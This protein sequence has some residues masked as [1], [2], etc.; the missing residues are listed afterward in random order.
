MPT[1]NE[2]REEYAR[3]WA[4]MEIRPS[5][6][7][8]IEATASKIIGKKTRYKAVEDETGVPWFVVGVIH[9]ME[10]GCDFATH[11]HNGDSL[12]RRTVQVPAGRPKMGTP[13][14]SWKESA[15]D[16]LNMKSL[17]QIK[18][19]SAE[20]ICY[21]LERYNGWGYRTYHASV[22]SPY[23]WSGTNHYSRGKY[24]ADG[25][26]SSSAVSGQSGAVAILKRMAEMDATIEIGAVVHTE[27]AE[28]ADIEEKV[29]TPAEAF[30]RAEP[31]ATLASWFS[32]AAFVKVNGLADEG[33]RLAAHIKGFKTWFWR[34]VTTMLTGGTVVTVAADTSKGTAQVVASDPKLLWIVLGAAGGA[35]FALLLAYLYVKFGIEKWFVSAVKDNRYK[36]KGA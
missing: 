5:K 14:F 25:K 30:P 19:W 15:C 13:P 11:L 1:Y 31:K 29:A 8:D 24:I 16:A 28:P 9:A 36:P 27:V 26:W 12:A 17:G 33:S 6:A 7:A 4:S 10:G 20:R 22:L 21:E 3:L 18:D 32:E 2:L 23:L 34:V 35:L